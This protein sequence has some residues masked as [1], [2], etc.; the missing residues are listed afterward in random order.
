MVVSEDFEGRSQLGIGGPRPVF[1]VFFSLTTIWAQRVSVLFAPGSL[2]CGSGSR[3]HKTSH[4]L[5]LLFSYPAIGH[6][7]HHDQG[8]AAAN[9]H[10]L[11]AANEVFFKAERFVQ[12]TIDSLDSTAFVIHRLPLVAAAG[13]RRKD[14]P[15]ALHIDANVVADPALLASGTLKTVMLSRTAVLQRAPVLL[16]APERHRPF[17]P[18]HRTMA[19]HC[20]LVIMTYIGLAVHCSGPVDLPEVPYI[21]HRFDAMSVP[22]LRTTILQLLVF[23]ACFSCSDSC[24]FFYINGR[25]CH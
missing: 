14:S 9:F 24:K 3:S 8:Q 4:P 10:L 5:V 2:I 6:T 21:Y 20:S 16:E 13:Q 25:S 15:V 19:I 1:W 11:N 22:E 17:S 12:T 7:Q 23:Y 18:L